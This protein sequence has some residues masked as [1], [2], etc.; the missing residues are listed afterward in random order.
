M[1][2][3]TGSDLMSKE[4]FLGSLGRRIGAK[5][6]SVGRSL[7]GVNN[8]FNPTGL[9]GYVGVKMQRGGINV[10]KGVRDFRKTNLGIND[11]Q[12][13]KSLKNHY[14]TAINNLKNKFQP[15]QSAPAQAVTPPPSPTPTPDATKQPGFLWR[16]KG[17]L[18]GGGLTVGGG[19]MAANAYGNQIQQA[20]E[21]APQP[22]PIFLQ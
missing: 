21:N 7:T 12:L 5:M 22:Q 3:K 13:G 15:G 4:A 2:T 9:R 16:N 18:L 6:L 20:S 17:K 11:L 1:I 8:N 10:L 19:I 14:N